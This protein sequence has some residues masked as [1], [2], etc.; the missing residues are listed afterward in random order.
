MATLETLP[1]SALVPAAPQ[2]ATVA[3]KRF[4]IAGDIINKALAELPEDNRAAIKW[5]VGYCRARDLSPS[6]M[7]TL[8]KKETGGFYSWDS[9]YQLITGRRATM[10]ASIAPYVESIVQFREQ[11]EGVT[12][13]GDSGYIPT[14][15]GE[16]ITTRCLRAL[17]LGRIGFIF[18]DSQIGKSEELKQYQRTHNHGQ[19]V[20]V[21][22]PT[23]GSLS[24]V[25]NE[26][27]LALGIPVTLKNADLRRRIIDAADSG[28]LFI[29]D[30]CHRSL[31]QARQAI[32][33]P[34][35]EFIRELYNRKRCGIVIC[36]TNEGRGL[37][38]KG[39]AKKSLEQLWRR[40]A[41]VLNLPPAP[42]LDD[43]DKYALAYGL[44]A[45]TEE[46]VTIRAMV[47]DDQG[48]TK[49][50]EFTDSPLRLQNAI[51]EREGLGVWL[52]LIQNAADT[53]KARKSPITWGSV[54][55]AFCAD[56]SDT[57]IIQ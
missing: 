50:Q 47:I 23:G 54:L 26:C 51:L 37:F 1:E 57:A 34:A 33:V 9:I 28:M 45:A 8:L 4:R 52:M 36:M 30:E 24:D 13:L 42:L 16:I 25:L 49:K 29:F 15:L 43:R 41:W 48:Q 3:S 39:P 19:T 20:Y 38:F 56:Q 7:S 2:I 18:G 6:Q 32:T 53:S 21:E 5:F 12:K 35:F 10:G 14:R 46:P 44:T 17:K 11:I 31:K 27:A 55:H 22:I 40:R